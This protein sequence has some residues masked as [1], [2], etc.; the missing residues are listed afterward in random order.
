MSF[1]NSKHF[2]VLLI[3]FAACLALAIVYTIKD[4]PEKK[5][6]EKVSEDDKIIG[7]IFRLQGGAW[8]TGLYDSIYIEITVMN[9]NSGVKE[10]HMSSLELAYAASM[11]NSFNIWLKNSCNPSKQTALMSAIKK[12][13]P[14]TNLSELQNDLKTYYSYWEIFNLEASV[15]L[16]L[17]A[18]FEETEAVALESKLNSASLDP[19]IRGC[20][21]IAAERNSLLQRIKD[22]RAFAN[23]YNYFRNKKN[24]TA[25][26]YLEDPNLAKY[27]YYYNDFK[28]GRY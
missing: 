24:I 12:Q 6:V 14:I 15:A 20:S 17:A 21:A 19:R 23:T 27:Q 28:Y 25:F 26:T 18:I 8:N 13:Y 3:L 7:N 16:C 10:S 22:F 2:R 4:S 9:A 11:H 5:I 1:T